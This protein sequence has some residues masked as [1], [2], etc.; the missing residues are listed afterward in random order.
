MLRSLI[1]IAF[2]W[3]YFQTFYHWYICKD[4]SIRLFF[5]RVFFLWILLNISRK[6]FF[7]F[8]KNIFIFVKKDFFCV[9]GKNNLMNL[10]NN[11]IIN[12]FATKRVWNITLLF[13]ILGS[14]LR[15]LF[16]FFLRVY[17][18][19]FW[20]GYILKSSIFVKGPF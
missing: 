14:F 18:S 2:Q 4:F 16:F 20:E 6:K 3:H 11:F 1:W 9:C 10:F 8:V 19:G 7:V 13:L 17:V 5:F 15:S 12:S